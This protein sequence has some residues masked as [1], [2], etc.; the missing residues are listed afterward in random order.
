[1]FVRLENG[2]PVEWPVQEFQIRSAFRSTSFP[3]PM[4]P[5]QVAPLG[6]EPYKETV[7]P[8]FDE[9]VQ[10]I[11][12]NAP[13]KATDGT[14]RQSWSV[15]EMYSDPV[16]REAKIKEFEAMRLESEIEHTRE[17]RRTAYAREADPLY[18]EAQRG[19]GSLEEWKAKVEEI[20]ARYPYPS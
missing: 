3:S 18:F 13:V 17:L 4:L 14:W 1:M 7:M 19:N 9:R 2:Q 16:E 11:R 8:E 6:F 15:V 5:E 12:E 20:C 10:Q